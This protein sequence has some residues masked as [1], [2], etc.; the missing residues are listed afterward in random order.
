MVLR[1]PDVLKTFPLSLWVRVGMH[2]MYGT[3][4]ALKKKLTVTSTLGYSYLRLGSIA[5]SEVKPETH[6]SKISLP[7][8]TK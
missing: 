2:Q 1:V 6:F 3:Y 8:Q 5:F 7:L 4:L